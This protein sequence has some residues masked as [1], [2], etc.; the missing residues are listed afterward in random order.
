M[1]QVKKILLIDDDDDLRE[2]LI[3]QF[4]MT[5]EFAVVEASTGADAL[6]QQREAGRA[7]HG[8]RDARHIVPRAVA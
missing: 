5:E 1:T 2:A 4:V 6:Q 7:Q 3:E 8:E